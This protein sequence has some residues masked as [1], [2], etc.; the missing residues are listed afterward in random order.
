MINTICNVYMKDIA[1][2]RHKMVYE[3]SGKYSNDFEI[4]VMKI[5]RRT[6]LIQTSIFDRCTTDWTSTSLSRIAIFIITVLTLDSMT[7]CHI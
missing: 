1:E 4:I 5:D 2:P 3:N 7:T 6:H